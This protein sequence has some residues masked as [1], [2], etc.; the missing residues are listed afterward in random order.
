MLFVFTGVCD[1]D[2]YHNPSGLFPYADDKNYFVQC[3]A[4]FYGN[5]PCTCCKATV[6]PCPYGTEYNDKLKVCADA[7]TNQYISNPYDNNQ[8]GHVIDQYKNDGNVR[9]SNVL[10]NK[11]PVKRDHYA[12]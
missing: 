6:L 5:H 10:Q 1:G 9:H 4:D 7:N 3:E 11:R 8:D 12:N 2:C